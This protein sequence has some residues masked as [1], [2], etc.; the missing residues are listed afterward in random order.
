MCQEERTEYYSY[1][2]IEDSGEAPNVEQV[3]L[4]CV[5][6]GGKELIQSLKDSQLQN[7][8]LFWYTNSSTCD[9]RGVCQE[10]KATAE[11]VNMAR[12]KKEFSNH[13]IDFRTFFI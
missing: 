6:V 13:I 9:V 10:L 5:E 11:L 12:T 8:Y 1:V 3:W 7:V 2:Y 4:Q